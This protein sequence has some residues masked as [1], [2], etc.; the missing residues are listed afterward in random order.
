MAAA[1]RRLAEHGPVWYQH[2][3]KAL[4]LK[5]AAPVRRTEFAGA[6]AGQ[7]GAGA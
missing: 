4:L 2:P 6:C 5:Q 1:E 3:S 7:G